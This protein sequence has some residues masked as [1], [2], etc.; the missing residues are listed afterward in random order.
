MAP[1]TSFDA[2]HRLLLLIGKRSPA[3]PLVDVEMLHNNRTRL[4]TLL[5]SVAT[6]W[7]TKAP[8]DAPALAE[9][10]A[11]VREADDVESLWNNEEAFD[12]TIAA[13]A[14]STRTTTISTTTTATAT[15]TAAA[16]AATSTTNRGSLA[17]LLS[18][19][20]VVFNV[21]FP[22]DVK[23]HR[24]KKYTATPNSTRHA[25]D[26]LCWYMYLTGFLTSEEM[27][28]FLIG[29][30]HTPQVR[31]KRACVCVACVR[32]CVMASADVSR[33]LRRLFVDV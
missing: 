1:K 27:V 13:P 12:T 14:T 3:T 15:T 30:H 21:E 20:G 6:K 9:R 23:I 7:H 26:T 8:V 29:A 5:D 17:P 4:A 2:F 11:A 31:S 16:E 19:L 28:G 22:P 10:L 33:I 25:Y 32:Q 18:A 24:D